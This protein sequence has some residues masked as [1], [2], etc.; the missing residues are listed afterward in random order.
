MSWECHT[1]RHVPKHAL[2]YGIFWTS[3]RH[4]NICL[5][6]QPLYGNISNQWMVK[7]GRKLAK[8]QPKVDMLLAKNVSPM[9]PKCWPNIAPMLAE[10]WPN[11]TPT[12][13]RC[14]A[15]TGPMLGQQWANISDVGP[16]DKTTLGW[17]C[18][19]DVSLTFALT[20]SQCRTNHMMLSGTA[21]WNSPDT[22]W[23]ANKDPPAL[24]WYDWIC[25]SPRSCWQHCSCCA[26]TFGCHSWVSQPADCCNSPAYLK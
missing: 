3:L 15:N 20:L 16:P 11:I 14:W 23:A 26:G 22:R 2:K 17:L 5:T 18:S 19:A 13:A 7:V 9:S 25:C 4:K 8:S 12:L 6:W 10:Y 24:G 21:A 1:S